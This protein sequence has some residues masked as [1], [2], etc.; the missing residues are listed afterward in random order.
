MSAGVVAVYGTLRR[1]ERN[2]ELLGDAELVGIGF[3]SGALRDVPRAPYRP[4][5]Y[6]ALVESEG[7][8]VVELYR[9]TDAGLLARLDALELYDPADE[10]GS[11]YVRRLVPVLDAPVEH[12]Y[13]YIYNGPPG[14]LGETIGDGDWVRFARRR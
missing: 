1:G 12:A 14:E 9:L 8:V 4:Y 6:P 5:A 3:V 7:R 11:Q 2:H 10:A 13:V